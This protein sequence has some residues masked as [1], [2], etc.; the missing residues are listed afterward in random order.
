MCNYKC[1]QIYDEQKDAILKN[2]KRNIENIVMILIKHL[3]LNLKFGMR[4]PTKEMINNKTN[5]LN[6]TRSKSK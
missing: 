6:P 4:T 3:N 1:V 2:I 5:K